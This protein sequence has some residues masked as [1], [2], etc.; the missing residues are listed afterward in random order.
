[1]RMNRKQYIVGKMPGKC[2]EKQKRRLG[3]ILVKTEIGNIKNRHFVSTFFYLNG[4]K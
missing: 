1:M 4:V 3:N 2:G